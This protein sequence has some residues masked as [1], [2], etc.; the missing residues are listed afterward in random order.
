MY[1]SN[2]YNRRSKLN[3][4]T[5]SM[6]VGLILAV[7][8]NSP[9]YKSFTF[10]FMP[11]FGSLS[12]IGSTAI[13][14]SL[15]LMI[16]VFVLKLFWNKKSDSVSKPK[17]YGGAF[18]YALA[19]LFS[20]AI[21]KLSAFKDG[22]T[23]GSFNASMIAKLEETG[24]ITDTQGLLDTL[25]DISNAI[26][27]NYFPLVG[28]TWAK[29]EGQ[30]QFIS[31]TITFTI[32]LS[33][34]I[35][36]FKSVFSSKSS[37]KVSKRSRLKEIRALTGEDSKKWYHKLFSI[38]KYIFSTIFT[39]V[40]WYIKGAKIWISNVSDKDYSFSKFIFFNFAL[41]YANLHALASTF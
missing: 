29:L 1:Y 37:D 14:Y 30:T 23:E 22:V 26:A 34:F 10:S 32:V 24:I 40:K 11:E 2:N 33:I 36:I 27:F 17:N 8:A 38:P 7:L 19:F 3:A 9:Q 28:G 18:P 35:F 5:G 31:M 13:I 21:S 41:V 25:A 12:V 6:L 20:T 39:F 15:I 4:Y 16:S